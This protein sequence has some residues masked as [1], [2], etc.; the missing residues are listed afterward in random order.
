MGKRVLVI[1]VPWKRWRGS[2]KRKWLDKI[3]SHLSERELSG[4]ETQ[5]R[6]NWTRLIRNIDPH[7]WER[8]TVSVHVTIALVFRQLYTHCRILTSR[9]QTSDENEANKHLQSL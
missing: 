1:E 2:P 6:I 4:D 5:C 7:K 3:R 8:K 9:S